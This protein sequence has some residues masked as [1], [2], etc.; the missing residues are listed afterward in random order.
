MTIL[1]RRIR[2][3]HHRDVLGEVF[4]CDG[5][6]VTSRVEFLEVELVGGSRGPESQ[7]IDDVV[8]V[9]RNRDVIG[10]SEDVLR[11]DPLDNRSSARVRAATR[12][13]TELNGLC[14]LE[15]FDFPWKAFSQPR[16]RFFHLVTVLK[17]LPEH[18]VLVANAVAD[19]R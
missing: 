11:V 16:I 3:Q 9:T 18:T 7:R 14:E 6:G 4:R 13:T 8:P 2:V 17:P 15:T 5:V 19:D 1:C 10:N 12:T